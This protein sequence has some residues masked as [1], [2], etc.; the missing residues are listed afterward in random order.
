MPSPGRRGR[1]SRGLVDSE[2]LL[3][4]FLEG[5]GEIDACTLGHIVEPGRDGE[6]FLNGSVVIEFPIRY[7]VAGDQRYKLSVLALLLHSLNGGRCR[8]FPV[9]LF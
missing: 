8:N 7:G 9:L 4:C 6:G 5:S 1:D 3:Q 2:L